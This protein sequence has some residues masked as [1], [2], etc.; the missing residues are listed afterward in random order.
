MLELARA[1]VPG[2]EDVRL[3][4][5]PDDPLSKCDAVV[6]V[7]HVLSYLPNEASLKAALVAAAKALRPGG[8]FVIDLLDLRYGDE[9]AG[10]E[11]HGRVCGDWAVIV[12]LSRPSERLYVREITSFVRNEDGSWRRDDERHE[13]VLVQTSG[14]PAL[15]ATHGLDVRVTESFGDETPPPGLVA[16]VGKRLS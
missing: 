3:L 15:L 1:T 13:N 10:E 6:S 9:L 2:A 8:A 14:I 12:K 11:I 16:I 7:G 4:K 5:L